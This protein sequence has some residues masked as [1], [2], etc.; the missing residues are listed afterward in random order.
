V[1][2]IPHNQG[3]TQKINKYTIDA[4]VKELTYKF[5]ETNGNKHELQVV[6]FI[7]TASQ[8]GRLYA[9]LLVCD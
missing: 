5:K 7:S 8:T 2:K 3:L 1:A 4:Y 9:H 6:T